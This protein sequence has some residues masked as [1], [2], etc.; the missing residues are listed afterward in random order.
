MEAEREKG[1][2]ESHMDKIGLKGFVHCVVSSNYHQVRVS[3]A[4]VDCQMNVR[5]D[6]YSK[7]TIGVC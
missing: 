6:V 4:V 5:S 3:G 2:I 1:I 7:L